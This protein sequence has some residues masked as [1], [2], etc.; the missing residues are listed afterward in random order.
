MNLREVVKRYGK[1]IGLNLRA[2]RAYASQMFLALAL[3]RKC[4]I[5]HADLKPDNILVSPQL[6]P[7]RRPRSNL[8]ACECADGRAHSIPRGL[9]RSTSPSRSSR[10]RISVPLRT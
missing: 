2:V 6:S 9:D 4:D 3:M 10:C 7:Y 5:M 8:N 1:D